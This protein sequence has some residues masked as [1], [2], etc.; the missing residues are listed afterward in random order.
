MF[1][2]A[3]QYSE[4]L[5]PHLVFGSCTHHWA[6]L[7]RT[8]L[9]DSSVQHVDLVEEVH[10]VHCHP[11]EGQCVWREGNRSRNFFLQSILTHWCPLPPVASQPASNYL[12][13]WKL[14]QNK[15]G[16][17]KCWTDPHYRVELLETWSQG[18]CCMLYKYEYT[19][20]NSGN[21]IPGLRLHAA[22]V[23]AVCFPQECSSSAWMSLR[24]GFQTGN[25]CLWSF[26]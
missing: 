10:C 25:S 21:L 12:E 8:K 1:V 2:Y 26:G 20:T 17:R 23:H 15:Q 16:G 13:I 24:T 22:S 9:S 4:F 19:N 3:L 14:V 18:L 5:V 11:S 6:R 7:L